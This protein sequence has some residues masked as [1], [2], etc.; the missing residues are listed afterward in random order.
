MTK[1][2]AAEMR[3]HSEVDRFRALLLEL[4]R[5]L[6]DGATGHHCDDVRGVDLI[7]IARSSVYVIERA[8]GLEHDP[9]VRRPAPRPPQ[10][11][12]KKRGRASAAPAARRKRKQRVP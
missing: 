9:L 4:R 6:I 10:R 3:A 12:A 2:T 7:G 5:D 1:Q 8:L 11:I